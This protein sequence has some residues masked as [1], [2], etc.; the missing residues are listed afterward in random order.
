MSGK[1]QSV[2]RR[3]I[4]G[5][6]VLPFL[7]LGLVS[8]APAAAHGTH[9]MD[10][11]GYAV[12]ETTNDLCLDVEGGSTANGARVIQWPCHYGSNQL[13]AMYKVGW[14]P[15]YIT[16]LKSG[17]CLDIEYGSASAGAKMIQWD[18]HH[19]DNQLW[20]L[21]DFSG[22]TDFFRIRSERNRNNCLDVPGDS[23]QWG[24]QIQVWTC[25]GTAAQFFWYSGFHA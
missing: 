20:T 18:C 22:N 9:H 23:G 14:G 8:P 19:L 2:P 10:W 12:I 21:T 4:A 17:R 16:N 13:W 1:I 7:A 25:N 6:V 24:L 15:Y 11:G 3:V 5:L